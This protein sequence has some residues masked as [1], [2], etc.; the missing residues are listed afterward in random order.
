MDCICF[1]G[2]LYTSTAL[3]GREFQ[4]GFANAPSPTISHTAILAQRQFGCVIIK[5]DR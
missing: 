5:P 1:Q 2:V 3:Q 4:T